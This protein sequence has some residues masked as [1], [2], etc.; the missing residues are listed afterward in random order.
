MSF[1]KTMSLTKTAALSLAALL[2]LATPGLAG[3]APEKDTPTST[4]TEPKDD[5]AAASSETKADD[6]G[7]FSIP[8]ADGDSSSKDD[9]KK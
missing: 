5:K 8:A 1:T 4:T 2:A 7:S 3:D 9:S 6:L